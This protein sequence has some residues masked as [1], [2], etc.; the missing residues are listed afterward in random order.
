MSAALIDAGAFVPLA[1]TA[2]FRPST[3]NGTC[4]RPALTSVV[5][6]DDDD[7]AKLMLEF[8]ISAALPAPEPFG[9]AIGVVPVLS[10]IR[11]PAAAPFGARASNETR[12]APALAL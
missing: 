9:R 5:D 10:V 6:S 3:A 8:A 12:R 7:R 1:E 4:H 2:S 11:S